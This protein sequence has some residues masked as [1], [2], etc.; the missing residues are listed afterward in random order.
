MV[1]FANNVTDPGIAGEKLDWALSLLGV[2]VICSIFAD[3][4]LMWK[5]LKI[6]IQRNLSKIALYIK[7]IG[8]AKNQSDHFRHVLG[9]I[10]WSLYKIINSE[11]QTGAVVHRL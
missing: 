8:T 1:N 2:R 5:Y 4:S 9:K 11:S 10:M 7:S 6:Y 3:I